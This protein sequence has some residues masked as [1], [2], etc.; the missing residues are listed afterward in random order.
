V[1][2]APALA[3]AEAAARVLPGSRRVRLHGAVRP[4]PLTACAEV[5]VRLYRDPVGTWAQRYR[6][7]ERDNEARI[8]R[9]RLVQT[10]GDHRAR[11]V[12]AAV[13]VEADIDGV[14]RAAAVEVHALNVDTLDAPAVPTGDDEVIRELIVER[15]VRRLEVLR[16]RRE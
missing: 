8:A 9:I 10:V 15:I 2:I 13:L 12:A 4:A 11:Q 3:D 1:A 16:A 6:R 5:H 14:G 7:A